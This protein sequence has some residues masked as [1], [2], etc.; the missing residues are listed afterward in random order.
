MERES[1]ALFRT[2]RPVRTNGGVQHVRMG[3]HALA[4]ALASGIAF[5]LGNLI[6]QIQGHQGPGIVLVV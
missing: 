4:Q 3:T 2:P 1:E 5:G 6:D